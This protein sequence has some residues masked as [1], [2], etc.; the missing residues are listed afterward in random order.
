MIASISIPFSGLTGLLV[1]C[2]FG[3]LV[4][5]VGWVY[6]LP[7]T[8]SFPSKIPKK[9]IPIVHTMTKQ[10]SPSNVALTSYY[11]KIQKVK[12]YLL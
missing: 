9:I 6:T 11:V 3:G 5:F 4:W 7:F 2:G 10:K 8:L 1:L 12:Q